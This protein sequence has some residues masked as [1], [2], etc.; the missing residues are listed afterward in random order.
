VKQQR[1]FV[2]VFGDP[3]PDKDRVESG[4]YEAEYG[5]PPFNLDEGD[6][7]LLYCTENY[8]QYSKSVPGIGEV[9]RAS[10]TIIEY[11]WSQLAKPISRERLRQAFTQDEWKKMKQLGITTRRVIEISRDSFSKATS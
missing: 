5:Y 1:Y 8:K 2:I 7:L 6:S 11:K 10:E 4:T 3:E 9:I